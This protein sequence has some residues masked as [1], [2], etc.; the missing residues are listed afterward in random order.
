MVIFKQ[1]KNDETNIL[2]KPITTNKY[3]VMLFCC[4][5]CDVVDSNHG[6]KIFLY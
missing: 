4:L 6:Q 2:S 1:V 3:K 5:D